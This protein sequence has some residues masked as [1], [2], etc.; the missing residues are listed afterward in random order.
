[1]ATTA[2]APSLDEVNA[3]FA[4]LDLN[5]H[6]N[7]LSAVSPSTVKANP[8]SILGSICPVY[9]AVRKLLQLIESIPFVPGA[10]KTGIQVFI[11][12]MDLLCPPAKT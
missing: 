5:Q 9:Q 7:T 11:S 6:K 8:A 12:A 1:M 4:A 10:V 3:S 2:V